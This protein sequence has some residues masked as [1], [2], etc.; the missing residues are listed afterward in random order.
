[1]GTTYL[2]LSYLQV[3]LAASLVVVN[4]ILSL[5]LKLGMERLLF[6]SALRT[7]VQL[8][9]I[10]FVLQ[11]VFTH[12][13]WYL[14]LSIIVVMTVVAGYTAASR[15]QFHYPGMRLHSIISIWGSAW[16]VTGFA[17]FGILKLIPWYLPQYLI[18]LLGM[19]LGNSLNGVCLA[20]E[21][22]SVEL[23][24]RKQ[25][26]ES[27]LALGATRWEAAHPHLVTAIRTGMINMTNA[28]MVV[29]LVSLPGMMTGQLLAGV[30]PLE[31]VKYQIVI[32]FLIAA[33]TMFGTIS[34]V[35]LGY[36]QMFNT[37]HQFIAPLPVIKTPARKWLK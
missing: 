21:R 24:T 37:A 17:V 7:V 32:M 19:V 3:L 10:G 5:Y 13:Q 4:G 25:E 22:L 36:R 14:S 12:N 2:D 34:V 30:D 28:M 29:G 33:T 15:S 35:L 26:V 31:A 18:P 6:I 27:Q 11:W 1:M 9:L 16:L 23:S 8:L 20:L